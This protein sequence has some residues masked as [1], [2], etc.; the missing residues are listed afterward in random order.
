MLLQIVLPHLSSKFPPAP[1]KPSHWTEPLR[2]S[3]APEVPPRS[4]PGPARARTTRGAQPRPSA[5]EEGAGSPPPPR[6]PT[7]G[8]AG[9][10]AGAAG[11][12]QGS[13]GGA[14][15]SHPAGR[16]RHGRT[17][18]D[19]GG[20][21]EDGA[22]PPA[23]GSRLGAAAARARGGRGGRGHALLR[24]RAH[25]LWR[26]ELCAFASFAIAVRGLLCLWCSVGLHGSGRS[27]P[28][29]SVHP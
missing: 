21:R 11:G 8:G 3:K 4:E 1:G 12:M 15:R 19:G 7:Q 13:A 29:E 23:P 26:P 22:V 10:S 2:L 25:A 27:F 5:G 24:R 6:V 28:E 9:G 17:Y 20:S 16:A 18:H 14:R